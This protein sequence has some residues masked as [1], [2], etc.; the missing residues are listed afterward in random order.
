MSGELIPIES[1]F[2]AVDAA[3]TASPA[4]RPCV[5]GGRAGSDFADARGNRSQLTER[6]RAGSLFSGRETVRVAPLF[7][8]WT[9]RE[10]PGARR[11]R[12]D[13]ACSQVGFFRLL[14]ET[15]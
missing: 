5:V 2:L 14:T 6:T 8:T 3:R 4:R 1:S 11:E 13:C 15:T 7:S 12:S 9:L 10:V